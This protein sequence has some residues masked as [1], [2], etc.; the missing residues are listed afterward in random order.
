MNIFRNLKIGVLAIL[1]PAILFLAG[2][3]VYNLHVHKC[4]DG[5]TI[6]HAHPFKKASN[7]DNGNGHS[8]SAE[9]C[10]SIQQITSFIFVLAGLFVLAFV[11]AKA[12]M[13]SNLYHYEVKKNLLNY[14]LPNRAPPVTC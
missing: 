10:F 14:L 6:V 13:I 3:A 8:H 5:S 2:N 4:V 9:E 7:T 12:V 11:K 1:L